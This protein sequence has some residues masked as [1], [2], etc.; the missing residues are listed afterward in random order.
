MPFAFFDEEIKWMGGQGFNDLDDYRRAVEAGRRDLDTS[1]DNVGRILYDLYERY[2]RLRSNAAYAC[3]WDDMASLVRQQLC[4]DGTPRRYRHVVI[5]EGQDFSPEMIRAL[6]GAVPADGSVTFLGD[7]AQ[8]IYGQRTSWRSAGLAISE[9]WQFRENY[10][11]TQQIA[12][13]ALAISSMPY[14]SGVADLVEP[15]RPTAAGALPTLVTLADKQGEARFVVQQ[16]INASRTRSVAILTRK[17]EDADRFLKLL[18]KGSIR[19]HRDMATWPTGPRIFAGT[20]HSAKGLEF[21]TVLLPMLTQDQLPEPHLLAAV[22]N[23]EAASRDGKLLYVAVTRA[24]S[25]LIL[26]H[27]GPLTNLLP[28]EPGLF[29]TVTA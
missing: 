25:Q 22:G 29:T 1:D 11:N 19:L 21:D 8:Q 24:R 10:R 26:T 2:R 6:V 7:M 13:L 28:T 20:Y 16:A 23:G 12:R 15:T 18:P 9:I 27:A 5:D 4:T 3:D 14:Y 17:R